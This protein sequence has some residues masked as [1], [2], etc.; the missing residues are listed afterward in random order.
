[1][2]CLFR[3]IMKSGDGRTDGRTPRVNIVITTGPVRVGL[4]DQVKCITQVIYRVLRDTE[5]FHN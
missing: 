4:G 1:M 2:I 3:S 5:Y